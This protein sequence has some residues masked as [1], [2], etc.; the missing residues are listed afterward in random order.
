MDAWD[1]SQ[2][3]CAIKFL[4]MIYRIWLFYCTL[5]SSDYYKPL[6]PSKKTC[7]LLRIYKRSP[8]IKNKWFLYKVLCWLRFEWLRQLMMITVQI[9]T[10]GMLCKSSQNTTFRLS[11]SILK[12]SSFKHN[13]W[14][15]VFT[16][17]R[18]GSK[19]EYKSKLVCD[20]FSIF[21]VVCS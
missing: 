12:K 7:C 5:D 10:R 9:Q 13:F 11:A 6:F 17:L 16:S 8:F 14:E 18:R 21:R 1:S 15:L 2:T 4:E 20:I 3:T 19:T